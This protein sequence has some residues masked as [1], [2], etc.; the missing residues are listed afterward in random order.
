[1]HEPEKLEVHPS[2][3]HQRTG[4]SPLKKNNIFAYKIGTLSIGNTSSFQPSENSG[5][6]EVAH[7]S[8]IMEGH[9]TVFCFWGGMKYYSAVTL[10]GTNVSHLG[11]RKIIFKYTLGGDMLVSYRVYG[12]SE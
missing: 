12:D 4:T 8:S 6:E 2:L 10:Q 7:P 9:Q 5:E 1:M 3:P 11:K